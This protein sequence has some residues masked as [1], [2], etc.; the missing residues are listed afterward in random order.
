MS[1]AL[2]MMMGAIQ[3]LATSVL[4]QWAKSQASPLP[5]DSGSKR[6]KVT[7]MQYDI[8]GDAAIDDLLSGVGAIT[9]EGGVGAVQPNSAA[10]PQGQ[11]QMR[12]VQRRSAP[13]LR[14]LML[15]INASSST[16][17]TAS[18]TATAIPQKPFKVVR[19]VLQNAAQWSI[20][21]FTIANEPQTMTTGNIPGDA[22]NGTS[23]DVLLDCDTCDP[24]L[25]V[26]MAF[27]NNSASTLTFTGVFFGGAVK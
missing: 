17:T 7:T 1:A 2:I 6:T 12:A 10:A 3:P 26:V 5:K 13:R 20:T 25:Q 16:A 4:S 19:F 22:F 24:G 23:V 18:G 9:Y 15:P 21:N 11:T 8:I 27:T 14:Y